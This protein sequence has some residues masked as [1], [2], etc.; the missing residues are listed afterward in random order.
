LQDGDLL[1]SFLAM[2]P[3]EQ[4][5][6]AAEAA[7]SNEAVAE[8]GSDVSSLESPSHSMD[9][10]AQAVVAQC[11]LTPQSLSELL[12]ALDYFAL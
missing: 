11:L 6:L 12:D 5:D 10:E 3:D 1:A 2:S 8:S 9:S 7:A 4:A